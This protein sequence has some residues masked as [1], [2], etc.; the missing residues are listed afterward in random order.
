MQIISCNYLPKA[1][2]SQRYIGQWSLRCAS[3]SRW[4]APRVF[5]LLW[6]GV[7]VLGGIRWSCASSPAARRLVDEWAWADVAGATCPAGRCLAA[8]RAEGD[9][10]PA[11]SAVDMRL[12]GSLTGVLH[13]IARQAF[14]VQWCV[15]LCLPS[16]RI[17]RRTTVAALPSRSEKGSWSRSMAAVC[18]SS[19]SN[20]DPSNHHD[21][22]RLS[23][24]A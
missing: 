12:V 14:L 23:P 2:W 19:I 1:P 6:A 3:C 22:P 9:V 20:S 13:V 18:A 21:P 16:V 17:W 15:L 24:F 10:A 5:I 7:D 11:T 4:C 8:G